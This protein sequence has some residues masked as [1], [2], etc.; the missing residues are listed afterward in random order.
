MPS[1]W[2]CLAAFPFC[3]S[4]SFAAKK[5]FRKKRVPNFKQLLCGQR[6]LPERGDLP[7]FATAR[8]FWRQ[9]DVLSRQSQKKHGEHSA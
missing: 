2:T 8:E 3:V 6:N 4:P 7:L 9:D 1:L 5:I